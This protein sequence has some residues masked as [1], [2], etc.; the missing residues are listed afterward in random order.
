[1]LDQANNILSARGIDLGGID[2]GSKCC[3][4]DLERTCALS[5]DHLYHASL[6][7]DDLHLENLTII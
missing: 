1:M 4:I 5:F 3:R 7:I 6:H 2:P